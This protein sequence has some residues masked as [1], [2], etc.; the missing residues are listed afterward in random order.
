[1]SCKISALDKYKCQKPLSHVGCH[2]VTVRRIEPND[3]WLIFGLFGRSPLCQ[4]LPQPSTSEETFSKPAP[5][6]DRTYIYTGGVLVPGNGRHTFSDCS[7]KV[8]QPRDCQW[9]AVD[10][11]RLVV[12]LPAGSILAIS[13]VERTNV[14]YSTGSPQCLPI[15]VHVDSLPQVAHSYLDTR[16]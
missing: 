16:G 3:F 12:W 4:V 13:Q 15:Q 7:K 9:V 10:E 2:A 11:E 14:T 6:C 8:T 1:M 5:C